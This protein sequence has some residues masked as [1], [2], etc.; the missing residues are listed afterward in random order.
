VCV[1]GLLKKEKFYTLYGKS[2]VEQ[3]AAFADNQDFK[4]LS[5]EIGNTDLALFHEISG[6][7]TVRK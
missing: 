2:V 7:T 5:A 4:W 6:I 3:L 1:S